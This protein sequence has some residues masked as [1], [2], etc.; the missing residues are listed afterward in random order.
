MRRRPLFLLLAAATLIA[1]L[2]VASLVAAHGASVASATAIKPYA[3]PGTA[4]ARPS[5]VTNVTAGRNIA[6]QQTTPTQ[7]VP[8]NDDSRVHVQLVVLAIAAF[9]VVIVG[10]SAYLLRKRLG[11]VAPPPDQPAAGH[12]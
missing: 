11:L 9:A 1:A 8:N 2:T 4:G 3:A 7:G 6:P 12:H 5:L 10:C